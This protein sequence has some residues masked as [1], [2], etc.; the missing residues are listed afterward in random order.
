MECRLLNAECKVRRG[1]EIYISIW[2]AL[3][4]VWK[5]VRYTQVRYCISRIMSMPISP[6]YPY[7][8]PHPHPHAHTNPS[9]PTLPPHPISHPTIALS[10]RSAPLPLPSAPL[11]PSPEK[12]KAKTLHPSFPSRSHPHAIFLTRARPQARELPRSTTPSHLAFAMLHVCKYTKPS[13]LPS[14]YHDTRPCKYGT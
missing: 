5:M 1:D 13:F 10:L 11:S 4:R 9:I 7:P 12:Q 14:R 2:H 6:L 3:I 8:Y